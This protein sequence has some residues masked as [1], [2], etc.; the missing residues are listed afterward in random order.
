MVKLIQILMTVE[1]LRMVLVFKIDKNYCPQVSQK[2]EKY[3]NS[4]FH[5]KTSSD[6]ETSKKT[7]LLQ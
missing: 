4:Y 7:K 2:M 5:L 3:F 6:K 1:Y